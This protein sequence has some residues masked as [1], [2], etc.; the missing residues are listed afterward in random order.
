VGHRVTESFQLFVCSFQLSRSLYY[1]MFELVIEFVDLAFVRS[2]LSDVAESHHSS[3][4]Q[5]VIVFQ[6]T[7]S[8]LDPNALSDLSIAHKYLGSTHLSAHGAYQGEL[9]GGK[10]SDSVWQVVA[11]M[12]GPLPG[13]GRSAGPLPRIL[14]AARFQIK[15][16]PFSSAATNASAVLSRTDWSMSV[17]ASKASR[18][19]EQFL[20]LSC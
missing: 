6:G 1:S 15:N 18:E 5:A 17:W 10:G 4:D 20:R 19:R 9:L 3:T 11:I 13:G 8:S 2:P 7:A 14:S 16:L 12:F